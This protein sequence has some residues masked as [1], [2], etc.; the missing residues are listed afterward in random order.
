MNDILKGAT[1]EQ[2]SAITA[3][4]SNVIVSAGAGSGKTFVLKKRVQNI[5]KNNV[6][7]DKLVILTFTKNAAGEMLDRIRKVIIEDESIKDQINLID[8]AYITTF[9]S[10]AGSLVK[11]YSYLLDIDKDFTIIDSN[12]VNLELNN[13]LTDILN[14]YY[15]NP[16][17]EF[18]NFIND[19]CFK[20]DD[21]LKSEIIQMYNKL[22]SFKNKN[23]Y[24]NN[25]IDTYY[26]D[27][28][29]NE[30]INEYDS[31][32][33]NL[34]GE[35][36]KDYEE[37]VNHIIDDS[38]IDKV[39]KLIELLSSAKTYQ[40]ILDSINIML[41]KNS[42]NKVL[43]DGNEESIKKH[44]STIKTKL[45]ELLRYDKDKLYEIY[46]Y[47]KNNS[48]ILIDILKELDKR[49]VEFKKLNNAYEFSDIAFKAIELVRDN[50]DIRNEIKNN[51]YEI[52]IDEY[53]DTNDIQDE[54]ISYIQNN[55]VY[56]V[57]DIKQS[58][59][60]FRNA[61]PYLFKKNYDNY[62]KG[63]GGKK[64]DLTSNF[65]SRKEVID[66]INKLFSLIMYD[67]IGGAEYEVSHKMAHGNKKYERYNL[68]SGYN[69]KVL[70][71]TLPEDKEFSK[72]VIEAFII[73]KDI[74]NKMNSKM[75]IMDKDTDEFNEIQYKD[76]CILIDKS[77]NFDLLKKVLE[78]FKIP[79]VLFKGLSIKEDDEVFILKNLI[80]LL[81]SINKNK[82]DEKFKHA[83]MSICRSYIYKLSDQEIFDIFND[84]K[85]KESNLYIKLYD[86]AK[87]IDSM[88]NKEILM[89]LV[90]EFDIINKLIL[91][92]DVDNRS[93]KIEYILKQSDD[94]NKFGL[95]IYSLEEYFDNILNSEDPLEMNKTFCDENAVKI[96]TIHGSKGLEYPIVY[97]P[98]L[99]S[100]FKSNKETK[101]PLTDKYG[102]ITP[103]NEDGIID[104]TFMYDLYNN[105]LTKE[106][107]SEKIRLLY[108]AITRAREQFIIVN[109]W[110]DKIESNSK[111]NKL[112]L[113]ECKNYKDII[114]LL[115][116]DLLQYTEDIDIKSLGITNE[117][118][119]IFKSNYKEMIN[120]S[121]EK[122]NIT[123]L[124]IDHTILDN[125]HF[126]KELKDVMD[127]EFKNLLDYGTMMH[128]CF[129]V[130]DFNKDN[131]DELNISDEYKNN[132]RNFLK[133]DEVKNIK[134]AKT[135]K[136]HE[137]KFNKDGS[138]FH[139]YIDLLV[140]YNDHFDII[141]YKTS[142]LDSEEYKDQLNGYKDYIESRYGKSA[143][144]YLYSIK[145]DIFKKLN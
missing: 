20:N 73:A 123:E 15:K 45:K 16:S 76:F 62:S 96:M 90:E 124:N 117:Y 2:K 91:V 141:D 110:N 78:Y 56:M 132:I 44:I 109:S 41:P 105:N 21:N 60:G 116:N 75:L 114:S 103:Y 35:L 64:I 135:Y 51:T 111:I 113:L 127:E 133:H 137:I 26:N 23:D 12:I 82:I 83:Y 112:D 34:T 67:D 13:I 18:T 93:K 81:I 139:G 57:G 102:I 125:K 145:K 131:L 27:N 100:S 79:S 4:G 106:T 29:I 84:N 9:D 8:S 134:N 65:R 31:L 38:A 86:L 52:M 66:N 136:E 140:E 121:N 14:N 107:I 53:Q 10:Y 17:N 63:I 6:P 22:L 99:D 36:I 142:N 85:L 119:L 120:K 37:L 143:N 1:E 7:I 55:N 25:Y 122:I 98:Y 49:I 46:I 68:D 50:I 89:K 74:I 39:N 126:S 54:F 108:V 33:S 130:Y 138:M 47:T 92:G 61:N 94:L 5:L 80:T 128:Y 118:N 97:M 95:D 24:L 71:Y 30:Y 72:D 129:E 101:Y 87:S 3:S 43:Y 104:N 19:F 28:K 11:K 48:R 144:I 115:K 42:K 88:S 40:E 59:Y 77:K 32:I 58:I 69:M 70:N